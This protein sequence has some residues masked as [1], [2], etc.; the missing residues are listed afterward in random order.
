MNA[1]SEYMIVKQL[2]MTISANLISIR[3]TRRL[4]QR[5]IAEILSVKQ[6]SYSNMET[7]T[8]PISGVNLGVL[9]DFYDISVAWFF[10]NHRTAVADAGL[11]AGFYEMRVGEL[12]AKVRYMDA[13]IESLL[14]RNGS[15]TDE[16]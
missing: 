1:K 13:K 15:Q 4:S 3:K 6:S 10:Q 7:G 2:N 11:P 16:I 12:E 8:T 9:A 5:E 14:A